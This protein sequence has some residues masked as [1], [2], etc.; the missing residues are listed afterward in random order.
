LVGVTRKKLAQNANNRHK[1]GE[2]NQWQKR[3]QQMPAD[4]LVRVAT[5]FIN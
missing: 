4:R 1:L 2:D 5:E 3:M